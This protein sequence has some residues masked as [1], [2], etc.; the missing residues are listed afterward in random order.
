MIKKSQSI[1]FVNDD[2]ERTAHLKLC[3]DPSM[4]SL[5]MFYRIIHHDQS[6]HILC[7]QDKWD[8]FK[9]CKTADQQLNFLKK[10]VWVYQPGKMPERYE[11]KFKLILWQAGCIEQLSEAG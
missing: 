8:E 4:N 7:S 5:P 1:I 11:Q 3:L 10:Q 9:R 6:G 2:K